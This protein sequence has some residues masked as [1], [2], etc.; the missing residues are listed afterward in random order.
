MSAIQDNAAK[1]IEAQ[2]K[3]AWENS[4]GKVHEDIIYG[5][6]GFA[7]MKSSPE[8]QSHWLLY[9]AVILSIAALAFIIGRISA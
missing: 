9:T 2:R 6:G 8:D 7:P 1:E 3:R 4:L 5:R